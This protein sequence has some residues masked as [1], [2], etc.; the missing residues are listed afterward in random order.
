M[1]EAA[2]ITWTLDSAAALH[3]LRQSSMR[4]VHKAMLAPLIV[5]RCIAVA[6]TLFQLSNPLLNF[7]H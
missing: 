3:D 6:A 4:R 2:G 7:N 1:R 5:E